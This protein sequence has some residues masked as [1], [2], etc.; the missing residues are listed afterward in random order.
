MAEFTVTVNTC[1]PGET[2]KMAIKL[3]NKMKRNRGDPDIGLTG[4]A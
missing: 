4:A 2:A 1:G 3:R